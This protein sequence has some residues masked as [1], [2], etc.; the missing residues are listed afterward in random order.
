MSEKKSKSLFLFNSLYKLTVF[1]IAIQFLFNLLVLLFSSTF[2]QLFTIKEIGSADFTFNDLYYRVVASE[3]FDNDK[4]FR[5]PKSTVLINT[6][7]LNNSTFRLELSS[8]MLKLEEFEPAVIAVDHE[9]IE[10]STKKGTNE[11]LE[12]AS[13]FG[14]IIF[15]YDPNAK[16]YIHPEGIRGNVLF[17]FQS[18]IRYYRNSDS[19]F[20]FLIA[21][22]LNE[23]VKAFKNKQDSFP[24]HYCSFDDGFVNWKDK[25]SKLF[26]INF[27]AVEATDFFVEGDSAYFN[28]LKKIIK[29]KALILGHLGSPY[30]NHEY[31]VKDKFR[32]PVDPL[33]MSGRERIMPGP[34]IYANA[35]E[36]YLHP[37]EM[38]YEFKGFWS[39]LLQQIAYILFLAF[40]LFVDIS[41]KLKI[42]KLISLGILSILSLFFVIQMMRWGIYITMGTTLLQLLI[43]EELSQL[44]E[45]YYDEPCEIE[46]Q[47]FLNIE[48]N[49]SI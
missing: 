34:V 15:A 40:V 1:Y 44:L 3:H 19:S 46:F 2:M 41:P 11:L 36:N 48:N 16:G 31:D 18:S 30:M 14:N 22:Q 49:E 39:V 43:I 27:K 9:F 12:T 17:P 26:D 38:F 33:A 35:I 5:I 23:K 4:L 45:P 20:A 21:K 25:E 47:S 13:Y 28:D 10:D 7:S 6:A 8:L 32:V 24:I 42:F 37:E 29:G